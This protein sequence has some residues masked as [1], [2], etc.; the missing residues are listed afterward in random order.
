MFPLTVRT[1]FQKWSSITDR[2]FQSTQHWPNTFFREM[3]KHSGFLQRQKSKFPEATRQRD[4]NHQCWQKTHPHSFQQP[5][6]L[7]FTSPEQL[8]YASI[9]P[10][11]MCTH[12]KWISPSITCWIS[13]LA[14]FDTWSGILKEVCVFIPDGWHSTRVWGKKEKNVRYIYWFRKCS[15][16]L[17]SS[18]R[19]N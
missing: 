1:G 12:W 6:V 19:V 2:C 18:I 4:K 17:S 5:S 9:C 7:T 8:K 11:C 13:D 3:A 10:D 15:T 14:S 16:G